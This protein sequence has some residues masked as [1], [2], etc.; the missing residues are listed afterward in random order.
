MDTF[1]FELGV[2]V[3]GAQCSGPLSS[4]LGSNKPVKAN[5]GLDFDFCLE[6]TLEPLLWLPCSISGKHFLE[7]IIGTQ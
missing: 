1:Q 2:R 5:S 4:E 7:Y 3:G 6:M